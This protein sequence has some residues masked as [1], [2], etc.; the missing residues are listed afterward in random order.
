MPMPN[1]R[2]SQPRALRSSASSWMHIRHAQSASPAQEMKISSG[3]QF[4]RCRAIE[5]SI[6]RGPPS[7]P[8]VNPPLDTEVWLREREN[9]C[10]RN[11][12][13]GRPDHD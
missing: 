3:L 11:I 2:G 7:A 5:F 9:E 1:H 8:D 10:G 6:R 4:P 13:R 12:Y